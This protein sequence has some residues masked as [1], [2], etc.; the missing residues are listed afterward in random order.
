VN[1][2]TTARTFFAFGAI[3]YEMVT[4]HRAFIGT[5]AAEV[6]SAILK[7]EPSELSQPSG[8]IPLQ[9]AR[10]VRRSLEKRPERRF[11]ST[12]DLGFA[13]EALTTLSAA[14]I[15]TESAASDI[16]AAKRNRR[17]SG[18]GLVAAGAA[19]VALA[20]AIAIWQAK[21]SGEVWENPLT[22]ARIERVTDF[23]GTEPTPSSRPTG[24]TSCSFPTAMGGSMSGSIRWE[25]AHL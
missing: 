25:A 19:A 6:I 13:L 10:I 22:N 7:E 12:S 16:P 23:Q 3:L 9:L 21:P 5:S 15:E 1:E 14:G 4:G 24:S 18:P 11:Q 17:R 8:K 20:V 2:S